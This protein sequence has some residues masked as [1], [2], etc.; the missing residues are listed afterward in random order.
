MDVTHATFFIDNTIQR[1]ASKLKQVDLL[2]IYPCHRMIGVGQANERDALILPIAFELSLGIGSDCED[3]RPTFGELG[4][5]ITQARQRR[6]TVWSHKAAQK[7]QDNH[8]IF[9]KT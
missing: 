4:I 6:A 1:H 7:I 2:T 8:F 9:T 3:L 5:P